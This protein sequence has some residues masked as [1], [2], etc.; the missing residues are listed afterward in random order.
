MP[1]SVNVNGLD[2]G[3]V[4][5]GKIFYCDIDCQNDTQVQLNI[6][7]KSK[8]F[9]ISAGEENAAFLISPKYSFEHGLDYTLN[10][11]E[12]VPFI[13]VHISS[14]NRIDKTGIFF[15]DTDGISHNISYYA[16]R[17]GW[18][19]NKKCGKTKLRYV[20]DRTNNGEELQFVFYTDSWIIFYINSSDRDGDLNFVSSLR[21]WGYFTF[22][23]D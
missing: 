23:S 19:Q 12:C 2:V 6:G 9:E 16:A 3:A 10:V 21:Q 1:C 22:D 11:Q 17:K 20:C 4:S 13:K 14:I 8:R 15:N 5:N 18:R 7:S